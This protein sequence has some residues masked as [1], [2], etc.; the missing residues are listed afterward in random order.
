VPF[1]HYRS[2]DRGHCSARS[3]GNQLSKEARVGLCILLVEV[4][5][6]RI[7]SCTVVARRKV[8][9]TK[10]GRKEP[11]PLLFVYPTCTTSPQSL[12][13]ECFSLQTRHLPC[14]LPPL[15][16]WERWSLGPDACLTCPLLQPVRPLEFFS[17]IT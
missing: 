11:K 15:A 4:A 6:D 16:E 5:L 1:E 17:I 12:I 8:S 14:L 7:E 3:M 10:A 13:S 2:L 9:F